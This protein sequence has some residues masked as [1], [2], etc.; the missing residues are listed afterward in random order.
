MTIT[1]IEQQLFTNTALTQDSVAQ[2]IAQATSHADDFVEV[3]FQYQEGEH[4]TLEDGLVKN[5]DFTIDAGLGMRR[6][7]GET[8]HF[9]YADN[10]D[11]A[12]LQTAAKAISSMTGSHHACHVTP[13]QPQALYSNLPPLQ[14]ID[15]ADKVALLQAIDQYLRQQG[16][17]VEEVIVSLACGYGMQWVM[18]NDG[19]LAADQ[20][21]LVRLNISVQLQ[22][23]GRRERG[24]TGT[25]GRFDYAQI[26][27]PTVWKAQADEALRLARVNLEAQPMPAGT[28]DVVLGPGW[29]GV[30]LHEA[31]GHGLEADFNRKGL[32]AFSKLMGK[33]VA[34]PLCTVIDQGNIAQRRGS[35]TVDDEGTPTQENVLIDKGKLVGY[36]FDK[37]NARLMSTQSTGNGRRES[38]A[39][40]PMPRMTNTFMLAGKHDP[41][42][43]IGSLKK[44][45]YA[46][47]FAGGQVDITSGKFVFEVSEAYWVENGKVQYPVKGATLIGDGPSA[48]QRVSMVGND[49]ALDPGIGTCGKQGQSVPV[50]VG[51]PSLRLDQITVGGSE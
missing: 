16:P 45:L 28:M 10:I 12:A 18:A 44:G 24:G 14:G 21:P 8:S 46:V 43:L 11:L 34:S 42:E 4:W 23:A 26:A 15:D 29:P 30:L 1:H 50:G 27:D 33:Q 35:L 6:L 7:V 48:M 39:H 17:E 19:T 3:F 49:F 5:G 20:R 37:H 9:A 36:L 25:G 41:Q 2:C 51:Q 13:C 32:S 22:Q 47:N 31:V 40:L 38:Y